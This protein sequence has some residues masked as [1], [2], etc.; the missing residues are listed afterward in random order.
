M[1]QTGLQVEPDAEGLDLLLMGRGVAYRLEARLVALRRTLQ[2]RQ[3]P[4]PEPDR[5]VRA[6][7]PYQVRSALPGA[8]L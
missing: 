2:G 6:H 8:C 4:F 1:G 7:V 5:Q 3:G